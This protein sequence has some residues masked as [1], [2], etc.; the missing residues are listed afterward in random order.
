MKER[1]NFVTFLKSY[2]LELNLCIFV[3]RLFW[4]IVKRFKNFIF[5]ASRNVAMTCRC[6]VTLKKK[7]KSCVIQKASFHLPI[8]DLIRMP[9]KFTVNSPA[10]AS[11]TDTTPPMI[12]MLDTHHSHHHHVH[13]D[14]SRNEVWTLPSK[15]QLKKACKLLEE[16]VLSESDMSDGG[17]YRSDDCVRLKQAV[18]VISRPLTTVGEAH[19]DTFQPVS[20]SLPKSFLYPGYNHDT[21]HKHHHSILKVAYNRNSRAELE[22][23]RKNQTLN[24]RAAEAEAIKR[25]MQLYSFSHSQSDVDVWS[26][27]NNSSSSAVGL[28][29]SSSDEDNSI[30]EVISSSRAPSKKKSKKKNSKSSQH[31]YHYKKPIPDSLVEDIVNA[32][33]QR[34]TILQ[35]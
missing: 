24:L 19:D 31:I 28:V 4:L 21:H 32:N 30:Q 13:F 9:A 12:S 7:G 26:N 23:A 5:E 35:Q 1:C 18:H 33:D 27:G 17:G 11:D 16:T 20:S 14:T 25:D 29:W 22:L 3:H 8:F 10:T 6:Y 15:K 2:S 34:T